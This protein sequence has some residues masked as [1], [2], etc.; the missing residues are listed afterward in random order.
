MWLREFPYLWSRERD[1]WA[2]NSEKKRWLQNGA[3]LLNGERVAWDEPL[4]FPIF[5]AVLFPKGK[6]ITLK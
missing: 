4:D 1:G 2:S 3:L 6:R 5:S